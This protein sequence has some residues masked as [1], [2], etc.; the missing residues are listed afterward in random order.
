MCKFITSTITA[1]MISWIKENQTRNGIEEN[2][3]NHV[4]QVIA[5]IA[6]YHFYYGKIF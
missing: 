5:F 6:V 1:N 2:G 3:K 4:K